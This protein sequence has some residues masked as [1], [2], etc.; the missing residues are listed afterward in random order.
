ML[1]VREA[2][3]HTVLFQRPFD[4]GSSYWLPSSNKQH[5]ANTSR[6]QKAGRCLSVYIYLFGCF[7]SLLECFV[8]PLAISFC[9]A[10]RRTKPLYSIFVPST[11]VLFASFPVPSHQPMSLNA[12]L[13]IVHCRALSV[14]RALALARERT[15]KR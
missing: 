13:I 8:L 10:T 3:I 12:E 7:R 6:W 4:F 15:N 5:N 9:S 11:I 1:S 14:R 2:I